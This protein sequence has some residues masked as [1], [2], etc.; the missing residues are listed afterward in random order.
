ME[1]APRPGAADDRATRLPLAPARPAAEASRLAS[2]RSDSQP[3]PSPDWSKPLKRSGPPGTRRWGGACRGLCHPDRSRRPSMNPP[4]NHP[5][6]PGIPTS[7]AHSQISRSGR[8]GSN[9]A[10]SS[11]DSASKPGLQPTAPYGT[12]DARLDP[13]PG[14]GPHQPG[15]RPAW[16]TRQAM[17]AASPLQPQ[18][19]P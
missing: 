18:S 12:R 6:P 4:Q 19:H 3:V 2:V 17:P 8:P 9:P 15:P 16:P 13:V 11:N 14:R 10:R 1:L 5:Q 7:A